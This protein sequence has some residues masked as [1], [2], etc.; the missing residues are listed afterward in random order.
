M[1]IVEQDSKMIDRLKRDM[2]KTFDMKD[3]GPARQ[4]LGMQIHRDRNAKKLWLSQEKYV[5]LVLVRFNMKD[6]KPDSMPL[7]SHF[8]LSKR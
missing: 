6:A 4:I 7:A 3:L 5:E 8:K 1:L 2:S